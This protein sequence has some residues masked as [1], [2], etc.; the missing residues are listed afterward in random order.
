MT[1]IIGHSKRERRWSPHILGTKC[2]GCN[3]MSVNDHGMYKTKKPE[4]W[5]EH[6]HEKIDPCNVECDYDPGKIKLRKPSKR[7][8]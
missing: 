2:D 6:M 3:C 8:M 4:Y 5:C 1:Y 7:P